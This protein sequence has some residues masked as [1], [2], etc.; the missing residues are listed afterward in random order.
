MKLTV[1]VACAATVVSAFFVDW[2]AAALM[3]LASWMDNILRVLRS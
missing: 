1:A 3:F 2:R